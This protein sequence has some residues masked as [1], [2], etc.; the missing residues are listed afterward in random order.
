MAGKE[1]HITKREIKTNKME[2]TLENPRE[3]L[4][5]VFINSTFRGK[6]LLY[7]SFGWSTSSKPIDDYPFQSD[8][9]AKRYFSTHYQSPRLG[10]EKPKWV[11]RS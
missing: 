5:D 11:K 7:V 9:A 3:G 1:N 6:Y 8:S 10:H 4:K 2:W